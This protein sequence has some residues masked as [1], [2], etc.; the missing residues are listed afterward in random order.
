MSKPA[1]IVDLDGTVADLSHRLH[2]IN[3]K[4]RNWDAFFAGVDKDT[5]IVGTLS[6]LVQFRLPTTTPA[7]RITCCSC[8][9]APRKRGP[10]P[11]SGCAP[12]MAWVALLC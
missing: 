3:G 5:P 9:A 7:T 4:H 8:P 6:S 1:I 12:T 2:H 11:R 10:L